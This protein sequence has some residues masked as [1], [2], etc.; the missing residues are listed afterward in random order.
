MLDQVLS[1]YFTYATKLLGNL[2]KCIWQWMLHFVSPQ[3]YIYRSTQRLK[4]A[5]ILQCPEVHCTQI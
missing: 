2:P 4:F 1:K 3:P 5:Q